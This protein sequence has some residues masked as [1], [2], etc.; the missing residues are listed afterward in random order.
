MFARVTVAASD[1]AASRRFYETVLA[2]LAQDA[3]QVFAL[4][5]GNPP[6]RGL[7][8]A[9]AAHS[10]DDVNAFWRAGVDAGYASDGEPGLRPQYRP[11]Y[12]G[13]FLLD[14]DGNSAEAVH[15]PG[16]TE[17]GPPIDHLWLG[18]ADLEV[19]RNFWERAAPPLGLQVED[20]RLPGLVAVAGNHRH[21]ML[22]AEGRPPTERVRIAIA[23]DSPVPPAT[24]PNDNVVEGM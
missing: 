4:E 17:T 14:P 5:Q 19:S 18:V 15:R 22:V 13:G 11:D 8:I 1:L 3:W 10:R 9:F 7:H 6:T 21:L 23:A 16:R 24:D 20:A 2:T 12:Y